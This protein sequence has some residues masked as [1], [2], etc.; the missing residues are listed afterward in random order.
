MNQIVSDVLASH[1]QVQID[2]RPRMTDSRGE[3]SSRR[4]WALLLGVLL[5]SRIGYWLAGIRFDAG[6]ADSAMQMLDRDILAANPATAAWYLH[7]QPPLFNL[8]AGI[9]FKAA[10]QQAALVFQLLYLGLTAVLAINLFELLRGFRISERWAVALTCLVLVSPSLVQY[11]NLLF[12]THVEL[13]LLVVA[14]RALQRWSAGSAGNA[15]RA[16]VGFS[17]CLTVLALSR[18]LYHPVWFLG[19]GVVLFVTAEPVRRRA[20]LLAISVPLLAGV[21]V[22]TK[23][24]VLFDW[25]TTSSIEGSNLHRMSEPFLTDAERTTLLESGQISGFS[26]ESFPCVH[27]LENYPDAG[28]AAR[29]PA[30]DRYRRQPLESLINLNHRS[31]VPCE[32]RLRRESLNIIKSYPHTYLQ[33]VGR[34]LAIATYPAAPDV[35]IRTG[36]SE[37]LDGPARVEAAV[38][39]A[40]GGALE[41]WDSGFGS[42]SPAH[43]EWVVVVAAPLTLA[44][45]VV[46]VVRRRS[47]GEPGRGDALVAAFVGCILASSTILA[48]LLESG[49]NN[50]FRFTTDPLL[51]AGVVLLVSTWRRSR[52]RLSG[53]TGP[54][55]AA[56]AASSEDPGLEAAGGFDVEVSVGQ[57]GGETAG[58]GVDHRGAEPP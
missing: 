53:S 24:L 4:P 5:V 45:L 23:N 52:R 2:D 16:L 27:S 15:T 21:A 7:I 3:R 41:F 47:R 39:G 33:A 55:G 34:A 20:L 44:G 22:G 19:L 48:Q 1:A 49:E 10:G 12:Y 58:A 32:R 26:T 28:P 46:L 35:R 38:L 29:N 30:L 9:V 11:E 31:V 13:V 40:P 14:A 42:W 37:A 50:R 6:F 18:A 8:F 25:F 43:V 51:L 36:N 54:R 57:G 17:A 56:S